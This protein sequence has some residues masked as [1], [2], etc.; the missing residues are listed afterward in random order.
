MDKL[1]RWCR[2]GAVSLEKEAKKNANLLHPGWEDG[3]SGVEQHE[4]HRSNDD[5]VELSHGRVTVTLN[6]ERMGMLRSLL[7]E[8]SAQHEQQFRTRVYNC[9]LRYETLSKF[10]QGTQGSLPDRVFEVLTES[11]GVTHECFASPLNVTMRSFNSVFPDVDK[12]FGS[13]GSFF[14]FWPDTGAFEAN[15]PFDEGS[16]AAMFQHINAVLLKAEENLRGGEEEQL[17]LLFVTVTPFVPQ[18]GQCR[19]E[20]RFILRQL[21][22]PAK[23]HVYTMGMRHR[24]ADE[25]QCPSDTVVWFVGN[26]AAA[27]QWPVTEDNLRQL[28]AAWAPKSWLGLQ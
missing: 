22:L 14:D 7:I 27:K 28:K 12:Y 5:M 6:A 9:L 21:T 8:H 25:W 15:P 11:F 17:P 10:D 16:V 1:L 24:K 23:T 20:D 4:N 13:Q 26:Q 2:D 3:E 19:P 18:D